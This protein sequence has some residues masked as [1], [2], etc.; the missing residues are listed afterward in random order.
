VGADSFFHQ[1]KKP[2]ERQD[3]D[4]VMRDLSA[5][6]IFLIAEIGSVHDGSLGNALRLV[7]V[8]S[9]CGANA[10]KFQT[11]IPEAETLRA[12]PSPAYFNQESRFDY[13]RRTSFTLEQWS[14]IKDACEKHGVAFLS[15][16]FSEEAVDLLERLGMARYKIPSGEVTNLP[17]IDKIARLG[18]PIILSSG[19]SDWSELDRAV[20][21]IRKHHSRLTILQCTSE[22]PCS[23]ERVGLNVMLEMKQRYGLPV[24]LSDHTIT[25]YATYA[26]VT[27]GASVIERHLT[28]NRKMYGSDAKHSLEPPEFAE[29]VTGVRALEVMSA[30]KVDKNDL[31]GLEEM[32]A[33]FEKSIVA[34]VDIPAGAIL[35]RDMLGIKKPGTGLSAA[36]I[37]E[38]VGR[39][40]SRAISAASILTQ[41]DI[42]G[43][44]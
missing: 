17:L 24:G 43:M 26:A 16:P 11:H 15:S 2:R 32:K 1:D 10:V 18:K 20:A 28:F 35:R 31:S 22:Y 34:L 5:S 23:Y 39:R 8:A 3:E 4:T 12:A 33:I 6:P 14:V 25:P 36:R 42:E 41:P 7:E 19:M 37:E 29:L 9:E 30:A 27:L 44:A 13:F 38:V 21:V 40:V